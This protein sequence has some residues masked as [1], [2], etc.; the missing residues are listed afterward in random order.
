MKPS[1]ID[2]AQ[3]ARKLLKGEW[4]GKPFENDP[5]LKMTKLAKRK[6]ISVA[7]VSRAIKSEGGK[8]LR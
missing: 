8:S 4:S 2:L 7:T 5:T 3:A 6:K 1:R